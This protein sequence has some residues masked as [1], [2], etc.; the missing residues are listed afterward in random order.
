VDKYKIE[1]KALVTRINEIAHGQ[2]MIIKN[3]EE[4]KKI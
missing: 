3:I 1:L 2:K 4:Y